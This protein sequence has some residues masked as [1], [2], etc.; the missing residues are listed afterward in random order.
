MRSG[1]L[2]APRVGAAQKQSRAAKHLVGPPK[3]QNEPNET[4]MAARARGV[5]VVALHGPLSG[6]S[7]PPGRL[8]RCRFGAGHVR[9]HFICKCSPQG[10]ALLGRG[11]LSL[12]GTSRRQRDDCRR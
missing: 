1:A 10:G 9:E 11:L 7:S 3:P 5:P 8:L 12:A 4:E 2:S 6:R